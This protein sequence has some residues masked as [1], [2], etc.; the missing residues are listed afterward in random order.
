MDGG[1]FLLYSHSET[2]VETM[3]VLGLTTIPQAALKH[4][5]P[6]YIKHVM[7]NERK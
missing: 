6:D 1:K 2:M 5:D 3:L 4:T 7:M